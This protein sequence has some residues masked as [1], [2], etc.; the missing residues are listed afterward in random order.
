MVRVVCANVI[1]QK[2]RSRPIATKKSSSDRPVITSG[3]TMGADHAGE[4]RA[5]GKA[6]IAGERQGREGAENR[7]EAR[8][9]KGDAQ[10]HPGGLHERLV[11][12]QQRTTESR[13]RPT[14]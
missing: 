2:P 7:R 5:A 14:R 4:E 13:S 9:Q 3:I 10:G 12:E 6:P 11:A 8:R 1:V